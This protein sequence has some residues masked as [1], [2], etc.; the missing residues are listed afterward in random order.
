MGGPYPDDAG[1]GIR[2]AHGPGVGDGWRTDHQSERHGV[3]LPPADEHEHVVGCAERRPAEDFRR[4]RG[5]GRGVGG[6]LGGRLKGK[7]ACC[8]LARS[9]EQTQVQDGEGVWSLH[10]RYGL[11]Y[12]DDRGLEYCC[13]EPAAAIQDSPVLYPLALVGR[14]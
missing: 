5:L 6:R 9:M 2:D 3:V 4:G 11:L 14:Q 12:D 8:L 13:S 1:A 7:L 10:R